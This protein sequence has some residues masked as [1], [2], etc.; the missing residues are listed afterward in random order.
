M[1]G[2]GAAGLTD[3]AGRGRRRRFLG[4]FEKAELLGRD[5]GAVLAAWCG[6]RR[7]RSLPRPLGLK[8][9]GLDYL[10]SLSHGMISP[11]LAEA[12]VHTVPELIGWLQDRTSLRLRLVPGFPDYHPEHPGGMP[13]GGRSLEPELFSYAQL[14]RGRTG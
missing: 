11:E 3:G 1:L 2:S 10:A 9:A 14:G 4:L 5:D 8:S 7:T 13:T 12:F 6:C